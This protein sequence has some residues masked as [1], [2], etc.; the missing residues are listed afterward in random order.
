VLRGAVGND[1][2][3]GGDGSDILS[4]SAVSAIFGDDDPYDG[5]DFS[6]DILYGGDG[7]DTYIIAESRDVINE[8]VNGGIDP[9]IA[10][11]SYTLGNNLE[12]LTLAEPQYSSGNFRITGNGLNNRIVGNSKRNVLQGQAGNDSLN[13][14]AGDDTLSFGVID[15]RLDGSSGTDTLTVEY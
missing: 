13:G 7:N 3:N 9:V 14:G 8:T 15:R 10:H 1:N 6:S 4:S 11:R 12:N 2:L 5:G